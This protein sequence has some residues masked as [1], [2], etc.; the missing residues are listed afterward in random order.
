MHP[1]PSTTALRAKARPQRPLPRDPTPAPHQVANLAGATA[2][3][4]G[5]SFACA[6]I[7]ATGEVQCWGDN[8]AGQ[9]GRNTN[10]DNTVGQQS[11]RAGPFTVLLGTNNAVAVAAGGFFAC[12]ARSTGAVACWGREWLRGV[13]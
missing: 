4:G 7:G 8:T 10:W 11:A 9:L 5:N 2:I 3:T 13:V 6:L 1:R 12:A